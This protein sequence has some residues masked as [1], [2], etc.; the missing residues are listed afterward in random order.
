M[1]T[2]TITEIPL[3]QLHES[4]FNP[5]TFFNEATLQ[6][7]ADNIAAEGRIH[8]P[9][10]VRPRGPPLFT[11]M[12]EAT[13]GYEIVFGHRRSRAAELAGLPTAPC[14]VRA[15]TDEEVRKAQTSENTQRDNLRAIEEAEGYAALMRAHQ[16]T[17]D[18]V[19]KQSGK[20]RSHV[21]GRLQLL[22]VLPTL[23]QSVEAG[24][25]SADVALLIARLPN[26]K[27]Q[28]K[29]LASIKSMHVGSLDDGGK[30]SY[31]RLHDH[32]VERYSLDLK[33]ALWKLDDAELLPDA[34]PCTTCPKRSGCTPELFGDIVNPPKHP[35]VGY[36]HYGKHGPNICTDPDCFEAKKK[37]Q[38]RREAIALEAKGKTV[39]DG[40]KARQA[41]SATGEVKGAYVALDNT[42]KEA[43][44]KAKG[45][46]TI[47]AI[48][49]PR[50][51]KIRQAVKVE[52]L[53]A[54]GVK[55]KERKKNEGNSA[56][57]YKYEEEQAR[58]K[59]QAEVEIKVRTQLLH[60][61]RARVAEVPRDAFDLGLV[62]RAALGGVGYNDRKLMAHLWDCPSFGALEKRLGSM[63]IA[64][65]TVLMMDCALT[66]NVE[67]E[68]YQLNQKAE[69]LLMAAQHYG[70]DV[71]QVRAEVTGEPVAPPPAARAVK[72]VAAG[73]KIKKSAP[74][75]AG[76]SLALDGW[77]KA[78]PPA[79]KPADAG[80]EQ[81]DDAGVAGDA[82]GQ[83]ELEE[84]L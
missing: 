11:G 53:K 27:I 3:E 55:V 12:P 18:Q 79:K 6:E 56:R 25:V 17:I 45:T 46:V 58:K 21:Y 68:P 67:V 83:A 47:I 69:T 61:V 74:A 22:K 81:T 37:A 54:A 73:K 44:K 14:M 57:D 13:V 10:L 77:N 62:A 36:P 66:Q 23:R 9:L 71:D 60:A 24:E 49:N 33:E 42:M 72:K 39:V 5:R 64:D 78:F 80:V 28:E 84:V 1:T 82:A 8:S 35:I 75:A 40:N 20:S 29:A 30:S 7:L 38:L 2:E 32:I 34:G 16:L 59:A 43:I 15:M 41:I 31:R 76:A 65:L 63:S 19:I 26:P 52:D 70:I 4:P 50:D 48:Q 51:G